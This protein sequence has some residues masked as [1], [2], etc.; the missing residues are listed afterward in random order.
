MVGEAVSKFGRL[1][2]LVNC[3][4]GW[5]RG[6]EVCC[7]VDEAQPADLQP[8]AVVTAGLVPPPPLPN[9]AWL[10][11]NMHPP[12][13]LP[14]AGNFLSPAEQLSANGF[15]TVMEIDTFGTFHMWVGAGAG[16]SLWAVSCGARL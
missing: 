3:A 5:R 12:L 16:R 9:R 7:E 8:A 14:T 15:R 11:L 10:L 6:L 13:A 1:D 2:I 4:G